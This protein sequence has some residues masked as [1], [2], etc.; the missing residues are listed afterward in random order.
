MFILYGLYAV[1]SL[2]VIYLMTTTLNKGIA[3]VVIDFILFY[4]LGWLV[5]VYVG[6]IVF[7]QYFYE[8]ILLYIFPKLSWEPPLNDKNW[9]FLF[10]GFILFISF[11]RENARKNALK[12]NNVLEQV[13]K[14]EKEFNEEKGFKIVNKDFAEYTYLFVNEKNNI[15]FFKYNY[16]S[17]ENKIIYEKLDY[18]DIKEIVIDKIVETKDQKVITNYLLLIELKND[19]IIECGKYAQDFHQKLITFKNACNLPNKEK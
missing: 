12:R 2:M 17:D 13:S 11:V 8:V 5:S 14:L 6:I 7:I 3:L 1:I 9:F 19:K 10:A 15:I 18:K 16:R 4:L